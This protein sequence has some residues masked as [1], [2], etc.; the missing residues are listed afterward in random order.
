MSESTSRTFVSPDGAFEHA[1]LRRRLLT[2]ARFHSKALDRF[3]LDP[4]AFCDQ[5]GQRWLKQDRTATVG[6]TSFDGIE[7]VV[8]R[9]NARSAFHIV[10]R[11]LRVSRAEHSWRNA[12]RLLSLGIPTPRPIAAV[13]ERL[14]P[15]RRRAW[16]LSEYLP[17]TLLSDWFGSRIDL[18]EGDADLLDQI[19]RCF[20][21][22]YENRIAHGDTKATNWIIVD[23][24]LHLIDL[25]A[26][27]QFGRDATMERLHR[28]RFDRDIRRFLRN[29]EDTPAIAREFANRLHAIAN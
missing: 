9:Y 20:R 28:K 24:K 10:K 12:H 22:M 5:M 11:A 16:Y 7:I 26:M 29:F 23:G 2:H 8:K 17:G 21:L 13:E 19:E 15:V 4:D 6:I 1:G 14:G 25:D 27:R 3:M 18:N